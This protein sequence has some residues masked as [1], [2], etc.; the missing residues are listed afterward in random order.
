MHEK[1]LAAALA[2]LNSSNKSSICAT[3]GVEDERGT[4][5][6]AGDRHFLDAMPSVQIMLQLLLPDM[7]AHDYV[8]IYT[9]RE[10]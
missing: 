1:R 5:M 3:T 2:C 9:T 7:H 6:T 10:Q 4:E 8:S